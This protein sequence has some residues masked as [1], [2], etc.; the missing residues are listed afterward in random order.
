MWPGSSLLA[1]GVNFPPEAPPLVVSTL[2]RALY[3]YT[4]LLRALQ[5]RVLT[6]KKLLKSALPGGRHTALL[7]K[8]LSTAEEVLAQ[9]KEWFGEAI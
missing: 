5:E 4:L 8:D 9:D 1:D 3:H 2:M 7:A 6:S